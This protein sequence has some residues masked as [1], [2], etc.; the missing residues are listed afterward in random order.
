METKHEKRGAR[1]GR[2]RRVT[3][4]SGCGTV[5]AHPNAFEF[6]CPDRCARV[7]CPICGPRGR[8]VWARHAGC[9]V[10]RGADSRNATDDLLIIRRA[11]KRAARC[12]CAQRRQTADDKFAHGSGD[13]DPKLIDEI[14]A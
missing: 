6:H 9:A 2:H 11:E 12:P 8:S 14:R 7:P 13:D 3:G 1:G 10:A 4:V 5:G